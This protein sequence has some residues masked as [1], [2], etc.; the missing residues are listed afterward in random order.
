MSRLT[1][2][3]FI[4]SRIESAVTKNIFIRDTSNWYNS[5]YN[6]LVQQQGHNYQKVIMMI[7]ITN[8]HGDNISFQKP[9]HDAYY[10]KT[11]ANKK[12]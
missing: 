6:L 3:S 8:S 1:H 2:K 10:M 7:S 5:R 4:D 9:N 12:L 11:T